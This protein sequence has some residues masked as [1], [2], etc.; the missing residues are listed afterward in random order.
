M[1]FSWIFLYLMIHALEKVTYF[2]INVIFI[3]CTV[4]FYVDY[5]DIQLQCTIL[6]IVTLYHCSFFYFNTIFLSDSYLF[7]FSWNNYMNLWLYNSWCTIYIINECLKNSRFKNKNGISNL[8]R[9]TH[10]WNNLRSRCKI[11]IAVSYS[12]W[13][14]NT[15][16]RSLFVLND[17]RWF[18][19]LLLI[20][21]K[22]FKISFC[23]Q[24][25]V[26]VN[27]EL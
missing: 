26:Q 12:T 1:L 25:Y 5:N 27:I 4:P 10:F 11:I 7:L 17:E 18:F 21:V 15:I 16:Y 9:T 20:L 14:S 13:I 6:S 2:D 19:V 24:I 8:V 3:W 23:R 22:L